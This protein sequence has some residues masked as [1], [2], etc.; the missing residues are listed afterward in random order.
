MV[1]LHFYCCLSETSL[2]AGCFTEGR[3]TKNVPCFFLHVDCYN[4]NTVLL[5]NDYKVCDCEV[6]CLHHKNEMARTYMYIVIPFLLSFHH[7]T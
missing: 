2:L 6:I 4:L 3:K 7:Y 1:C 5:R